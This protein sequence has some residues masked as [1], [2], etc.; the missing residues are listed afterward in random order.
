MCGFPPP[1]F[2]FLNFFYSLFKYYFCY[3][4]LFGAARRV[5]LNRVEQI[6]AAQPRERARNDVGQAF[7]AGYVAP[8]ALGEDFRRAYE[9]KIYHPRAL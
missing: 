5:Y 1:F 6:I 2:S 3:R 7:A 9:R 4:H 8:D